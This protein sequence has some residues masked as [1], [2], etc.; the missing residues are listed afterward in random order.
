MVAL[1]PAT[2]D[3][4]ARAGCF[5]VLERASALANLRTMDGLRQAIPLFREAAVGWR[6]VGDIAL[7]MST[8]DSLANLTGFFTQFGLESS[9]ARERLTV[10][11][12]QTEER[13]Q[14]A[15]NWRQL[16]RKYGQDGR[17]EKAKEAV[18]RAMDLALALGL[19]VTA[20]R[21]Q[22][23]LGNYEF[24]LGN[25]QT[26]RELAQRAYDLAAAIPDPATKRSPHGTWPDSTIS[27]AIL[28]R[29]SREASAR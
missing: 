23:E 10:L 25:Y 19:R 9:A 1:R 5:D 24:D 22:R 12:P 28:T 18:G 8:L 15:W 3:N 27:R 21:S 7:E 4:R 14:E 29:R 26:A 17:L 2:S 20:A 16:A 6:A 11:Y 13:E